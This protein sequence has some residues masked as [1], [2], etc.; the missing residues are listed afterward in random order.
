M[1]DID[2]Y[3]TP[4]DE[5]LDYEDMDGKDLDLDSIAKAKPSKADFQT[6]SPVK[7]NDYSSN[8]QITAPT[9]PAP[10]HYD[11]LAPRSH[12]DVLPPRVSKS[13]SEIR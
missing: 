10:T 6:T 2:I 11:S 12:Y 3:E 9:I 4:I 1:N 8:P 13:L 5:T 7:E